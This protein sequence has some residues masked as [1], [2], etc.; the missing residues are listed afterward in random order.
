MR[1]AA[2]HVAAQELAVDVERASRASRSCRCGPLSQLQERE[3]AALQLRSI[4]GPGSRAQPRK[5]PAHGGGNDVRKLRLR[6]NGGS[7]ERHIRAQQESYEGLSA[8]T[9]DGTTHLFGS[10]GRS[11]TRPHVKNEIPFHGLLEGV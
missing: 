2:Q 4:A 11:G 9:N 6:A 8:N 10:L 7:I 1:D 5:G 3:P